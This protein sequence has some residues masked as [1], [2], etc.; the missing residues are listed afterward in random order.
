MLSIELSDRALTH[1]DSRFSPGIEGMHCNH[2]I[3]IFKKHIQLKSLKISELVGYG[4]NFSLQSEDLYIL[5]LQRTF[6]ESFVCIHGESSY[7]STSAFPVGIRK[8]NP[9]WLPLW[10]CSFLLNIY[11]CLCMSL[12]QAHSLILQDRRE[13]SV[14]QSPS[15]MAQWIKKPLSLMSVNSRVVGGRSSC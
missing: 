9:G 14:K 12:S 11:G 7:H 4:W 1:R 5:S 10:P 13:Y 2:L 6:F 3:F 8:P 15:K